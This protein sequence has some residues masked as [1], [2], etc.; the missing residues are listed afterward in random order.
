MNY[1]VQVEQSKRVVGGGGKVERKDLIDEL[2]WRIENEIGRDQIQ[3]PFSGQLLWRL[4]DLPC[5]RC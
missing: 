3:V 2:A 1:Y 4:H 5:R